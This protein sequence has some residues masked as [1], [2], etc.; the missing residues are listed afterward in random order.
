MKYVIIILT[1]KN[2]IMTYEKH[3]LEEYRMLRKDYVKRQANKEIVVCD[4]FYGEELAGDILN[5]SL[6]IPTTREE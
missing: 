2:W 3:T 1:N 5:E 6:D 4:V